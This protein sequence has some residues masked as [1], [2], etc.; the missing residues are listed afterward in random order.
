MSNSPNET[1]AAGR[2]PCRWRGAGVL[3][4][5]CLLGACSLLP[6]VGQAPPRAAAPPPAYRAALRLIAEGRDAEAEPRLEALVAE[7]PRLAGAWLNLGLLYA[8]SDRPE[9][10]R[11]VLQQAL[12]VHPGLAPAHN[13]LGILAREDGDF[14]AARRAYERAI[15]ADPGYARAELNLGILCD[16]YLARPGEAL[17]HYR[18]FLAIAGDDET[19]LQWVAEL[20]QRAARDPSGA[21]S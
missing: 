3:A 18:R 17:V 4:A 5:L 21:G 20:E 15:A 11:A 16:L 12:R 13:A 8:R 7:R 10:A 9:A 1:R 14:V 6:P 2:G 19:V